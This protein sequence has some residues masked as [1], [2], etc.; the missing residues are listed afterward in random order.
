M[1]HVILCFIYSIVLS[2]DRNDDYDRDPKN[3]PGGERETYDGP[4]G[5]DPDGIIQ[6]NWDEVSFKQ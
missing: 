1:E 3:G 2:L 5:M 6:S 4:A